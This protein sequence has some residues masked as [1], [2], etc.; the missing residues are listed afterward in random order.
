MSPFFPFRFQ[1]PSPSLK[2]LLRAF[3]VFFFLVRNKQS[4]G[5]GDDF[6]GDQNMVEEVVRYLVVV[7]MLIKVVMEGEFLKEEVF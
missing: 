3:F 1:T 2:V 6:K 5:V 4:A 7:K